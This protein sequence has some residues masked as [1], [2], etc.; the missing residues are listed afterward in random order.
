VW[1]PDERL[2]VLKLV[3]AVPP[4]SAISD[5]VATLS[6]SSWTVPV[7]VAV[8]PAVATLMLRASVLLDV[9]Q[10]GLLVVRVVF[11]RV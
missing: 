1:P 3:V 9:P 5:P 8:E 10:A 6:T 4:E 11:E 2:A 7:G